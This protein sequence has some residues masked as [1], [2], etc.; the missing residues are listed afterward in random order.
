MA[1]DRPK[2]PAALKR[3]LLVE[4]GHRCA[5]PTCRQATPLQFDHI[6]DWAKVRKHEFSNMIVLCANCHARKTAGNIDRKSIHLY[7]ANLSVLNNRYGDLEKRVLELFSMSPD[8]D[9]LE[10]QGGLDL[11]LWYLLRDE[12]LEKVNRG[13]G[14]ISIMGIPARE[15]YKITG[16]GREFVS[17]WM[18]ARPVD[19]AELELNED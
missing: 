19:G 12:M 2:I 13:G 3:E 10:L 1:E 6:E 17:K 7:K 8:A 15:S 16:K 11:Q 5:I 4:A 14:M 18:A 9:I